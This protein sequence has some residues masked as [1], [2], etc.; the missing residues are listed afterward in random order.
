[1]ATLGVCVADGKV[2]FTATAAAVLGEIVRT[3]LVAHGLGDGGVE[4]L[5]DCGRGNG[6]VGVRGVHPHEHRRSAVA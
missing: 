4:D 3:Y 5:G 6:T 1:M 2:S